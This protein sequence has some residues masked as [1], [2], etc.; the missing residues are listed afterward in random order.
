MLDV[1]GDAI[2]RSVLDDWLG[3]LGL[4]SEWDRVK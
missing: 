1:S 2:D 4:R 3:R